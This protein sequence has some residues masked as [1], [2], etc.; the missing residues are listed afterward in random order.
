MKMIKYL[1]ESIER[2]FYSLNTLTD[3]GNQGSFLSSSEQ[4]LDSIESSKNNNNDKNNINQ[5]ELYE[6]NQPNMV[7]ALIRVFDRDTTIN[8]YKFNLQLLNINGEKNLEKQ[9]LTSMF[10][11]RAADRSNREYELTALT[12]FDAEL[13]QFYT[14]KINLYDLEDDSIYAGNIDVLN[15][16]E[17]H[18]HLSKENNFHVSMI[19]NVKIIDINDNKPE[20]ALKFYEFIIKENSP[21]L[22]MNTLGVNIEVF[23][24]DSSEAYSRLN[25]KIRDK[26]S[27]N[28]NRNASDHFMVDFTN[29]YNRPI[30]FV[31]KTFDYELDG[32]EL[33]FFLDAF[34]KKNQTDSALIIVKIQDTNDNSPMFLN[35]NT[36]FTIK[37]NTPVNSFIGQIIAIDKD[38]IGPNSDLNFRIIN[39]E[40][41]KNIFKLFKTGVISNWKQLDREVQGF[42]TVKI[43][44]Y[45]GGEPSLS[46]VGTFHIQVEDQVCI[47]IYP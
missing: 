24:L 13:A 46:T 3:Y 42:Y 43:E 33:Q 7:L 12:S 28:S 32:A 18:H 45:D 25:F 23:D 5:I 40:N 35:E 8:N 22:T 19:Q 37:E 34:D 38:S 11:I 15:M 36:T 39:N 27:L 21:N 6:N 2:G 30:L 44:V 47:R 14:L 31:K 1:N 10:E 16:D 41:Y 17:N 4:S 26:T 9:D 29:D 20:F